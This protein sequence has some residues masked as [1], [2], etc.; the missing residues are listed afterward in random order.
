MKQLNLPHL[1]SLTR[2]AKYAFLRDAFLKGFSLVEVTLALGIVSF[3]LLAT[4]GLLPV[5]LRAVKNANEQAAAANL[6]NA[7]ANSLRTATSTNGTIFSS[8]FADKDITYTAYTVS[9]SPVSI[10]WDDLTLDGSVGTANSPKRLAARLDITPPTAQL[11]TGTAVISVAWSA[12]ASPTWN[13][14][15]QTWTGAEGSILSGV[16]FLPRR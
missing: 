7:I 10:V 16:Q 3:A 2:P 9:G 11:P 8:R 15:D 6:L 4:V 12:Q 5:G 1:S 14:G 13:R